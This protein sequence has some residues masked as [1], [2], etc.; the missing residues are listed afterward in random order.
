LAELR[1]AVWRALPGGLWP[2][3]AVIL[4]RL[5]RRPDGGVDRP[6]LPPPDERSDEDGDDALASLLVGMWGEIAG[7]R[8]DAATPYWQDFSFLQVLAEARAAGLGITDEDVGR[9]RTLEGLAAAVA[10][11]R[12]QP[13]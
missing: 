4:D 6:A 2:S 13:G 10:A 3:A 7:R 1:R 8:V 12:A 11:R 9:T 5:P